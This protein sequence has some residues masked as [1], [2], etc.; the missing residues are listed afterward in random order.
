MQGLEFALILRVSG[1]AAAAS[2]TNGTTFR[3]YRPSVVT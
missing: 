1:E 3:Y 2:E